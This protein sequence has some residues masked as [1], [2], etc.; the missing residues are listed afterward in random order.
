MTTTQME[1]WRQA[2][3]AWGA[4]ARDWAYLAEDLGRAGYEA[5]FD[6]VGITEGTQLLDIGCG[7]GLA[8]W[9]AAKRGASVAGVDASDALLHIARAR[10]PTAE[11]RLGPIDRLPL[12]DQRFDVATS[13]N[14]IWG[15]DDAALHE[16]ARVVRPAGRIALLFFGPLERMDHAAYLVALAGLAPPSD[17]T[18]AVGALDICRPGYA[19]EMMGRAGIEP[20]H[21]ASVEATSEWP[22]AEIA[23]RA[24]AATGVAW[25]AIAH[26]GE[27]AT[28]AAV[29]EA[30]APY[31][32]PDTGYRM[33]A[34]FEYVL[35]RR[36]H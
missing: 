31:E 14:A 7:A 17:G 20:L 9:I 6:A 5:V 1:P 32:Q 27:T 8:A 23:W 13:F 11:F 10:V 33:S 22:D 35:G 4:R 12:Q 21:R 30:I 3:L 24:A 19:E 26:R 36:G 29:L 18:G 28:K 2:G 34:S 25:A 16:A 15:G